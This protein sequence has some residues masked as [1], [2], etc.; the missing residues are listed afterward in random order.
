MPLQLTLKPYEKFIVNGCVMRNTGRKTTLVF[1]SHADVVR[2]D[3]LLSSKA[4]VTP[5]NKAY[6]FVQT[7]LTR[8]DLRGQLVPDIQKQLAALATAFG[9][10]N[11]QHVF[12]AANWV[13]QSEFYKALAAMRPL[14]KREAEVLGATVPRTKRF[15]EEKVRLSRD[16]QEKVA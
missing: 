5:V 13:S 2:G 1:E 14:M 8:P 6:Y 3:D 7:A 9:P 12:E 10:P 11:V 15:E 4:A 16:S